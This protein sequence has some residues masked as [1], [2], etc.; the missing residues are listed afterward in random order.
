MVVAVAGYVRQRN[1]YLLKFADEEFDGLQ[2]HVKSMTL[3]D[4]RAFEAQV[5]AFD[6]DASELA[7]LDSILEQFAGVLLRWNLQEHEDPF[8]EETPVVDVPPTV[9]GL[10]SQELPFVMKIIDAWMTAT[11]GVDGPLGQGSSDGR[12]S[13]ELASMMEP[14][15]ASQ[16]S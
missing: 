12:P 1:I 6:D 4:F 2:V 15:S 9:D 7:E 5:E 16:A 13:E 14:L 8:D 11:V 3:G 10:R